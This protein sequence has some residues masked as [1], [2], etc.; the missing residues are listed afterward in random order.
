LQAKTIDNSQAKSRSKYNSENSS[1]RQHMQDVMPTVKPEDT[2]NAQTNPKKGRIVCHGC[3]G[4]HFFR[5]CPTK[6]QMGQEIDM[7]IRHKGKLR[8]R[9]KS[10]KETSYTQ[11]I[12]A[13]L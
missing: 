6:R 5:D 12:S 2:N 4:P 1:N 10:E 13:T 11:S 7:F 3:K 8:G 9:K